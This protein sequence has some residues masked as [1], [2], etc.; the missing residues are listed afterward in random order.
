LRRAALAQSGRR[1]RPQHR[2]QLQPARHVVLAGPARVPSGVEV[3]CVG[4]RVEDALVATQGL[5]GLVDQGHRLAAAQQVRGDLPFACKGGVCGTCRA[6][7]TDGDVVMR[8]NFAL[9]DDEID[10]GFVLTC[11]TLPVSD[12]V[13]VDF[14]S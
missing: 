8:R 12:A 7:V 10:A 9:E 6:K 4:G 2:Q 13:T 1:G 5:T 11:Q 3:R 14:D